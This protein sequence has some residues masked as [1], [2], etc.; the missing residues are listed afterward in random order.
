MDIVQEMECDAQMRR[1]NGHGYMKKYKEKPKTSQQSMSW[2][3]T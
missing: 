3:I 2:A 1:L